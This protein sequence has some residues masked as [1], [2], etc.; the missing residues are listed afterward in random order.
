MKSARRLCTWPCRGMQRL[1]G[2]KPAPRPQLQRDQL[3]HAL[4]KSQ[5]QSPLQKRR[6]IVFQTSIKSI[7]NVQTFLVLTTSVPCSFNKCPVTCRVNQRKLQLRKQRIPPGGERSELFWY[8]VWKIVLIPSHICMCVRFVVWYG[9]RSKTTQVA[10]GS[11]GFS[12]Q[13]HNS[14]TNS[15]LNRS[16][17]N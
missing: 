12:F 14:K 6:L 11:Q 3:L 9:R 8:T 1:R 17:V 5:S 13:K 15:V 7:K 2:R 16:C 4:I 10:A